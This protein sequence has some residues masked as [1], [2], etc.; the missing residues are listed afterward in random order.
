MATEQT[1]RDTDRS[2]TRTAIIKVAAGLLGH[3]GA[4]AVTTRSV[5]AEAGVQA[6]TIYRLFGDKEGLLDAVAE[7]VF[8]GYIENKA[9]NTETAD[10][11]ADLDRGW[12]H[13]IDFG[14]ANPALFA[15][16]SD[17]VRG[18]RLASTAGGVDIL[19]RRVH[20]VAAAGRLAVGE[21]RA[22][23]MIHAAGTGAVLA[24]LAAQPEQRDVSLADAIYQA[25]KHAIVTDADDPSSDSSHGSVA[26]SVGAAVTLRA[27]IDDLGAL[28]SAERSLLT[29]WLDRVADQ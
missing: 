5:A 11:V 23:E 25:V 15:L 9:R 22:V 17:P 27:G 1:T 29:E 26:G 16:L 20:R 2:R 13:H 19:S 14:L 8:A 12:Q 3:S 10:P 18:K 28:S 7:H 24:L 21:R 4:E 6:P